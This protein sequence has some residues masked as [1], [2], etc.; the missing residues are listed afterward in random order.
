[1]TTVAA[2]HFMAVQSRTGPNSCRGGAG[3]TPLPG[4]TSPTAQADNYGP[5][6]VEIVNH[7]LGGQS[8]PQQQRNSSVTTGG[9]ESVAPLGGQNTRQSSFWATGAQPRPHAHQWAILRE[10]KEQ[11]RPAMTRPGPYWH[12][13]ETGTHVLRGGASHTEPESFLPQKL[14]N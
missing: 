8:G 2:D 9:N 11:K 4:L 14:D 12:N 5:C 10:G 13:K 3:P 7:S 6:P 1:M